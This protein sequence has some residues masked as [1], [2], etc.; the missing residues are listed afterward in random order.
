[1]ALLF[2]LIIISN[3]LKAQIFDNRR[4]STSINN[5]TSI[6][7]PVFQNNDSYDEGGSISG[8][9]HVDYDW[10]DDDPGGPGGGGNPPIDDIP[11]DGGVGLLLG[12]G[13]VGGYIVSKKKII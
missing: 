4:G 6:D 3:N 10:G 7:A 8:D 2:S 1:I 11:F 12:I 9:P 5:G 13:V